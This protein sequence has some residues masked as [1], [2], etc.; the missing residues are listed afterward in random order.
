LALATVMAPPR[1]VQLALC[2]GAAALA[3]AAPSGVVR[4]A[5]LAV[6]LACVGLAWGALRMDALGDSILLERVGEARSARVVVTSA[7]RRWGGRARVFGEIRRFGAESIRERVLLELPN[8]RAPPRGAIAEIVR[9]RLY[10]P[11]GPETG[12]DERGWLAGRGVHVVVRAADVAVVGRRGG[13]G[14]VADRLRA[15][16]ERSLARG[17]GGERRALLRGIVLGDDSALSPAVRD[18]FRASG[19]A[20]LTA[21]SGQN[22]AIVALGIAA[23]AWLF[24]IGRL[25]IQVCA[26][27]AIGAYALAVG[28]EPSV[29][30][31]T[32]AGSVA[33]LAV[34]AARRVD[35]WHALSLGALL[36]LVWRPSSWLDPGFQLSFVAVA[37]I[38]ATVRRVQAWSEG[39]PRAFRPIIWT[40][41]A[42]ACSVTTAPVVWLHFGYVARRK[43][44]RTRSS[45]SLPSLSRC[46]LS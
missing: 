18:E 46:R 42:I 1:S 5:A 32:V 37:A 31:A 38:L 33:C 28:W 26:I 7:P 29:A 34:L 43:T 39:Y 40:S 45:E 10:A 22:V 14:G 9:A 41:V 24:A 20:H 15:H 19:L 35:G 17:A 25:G 8:E 13:I 23:L 16:V 27:L 36:L 30:R 4:V 12:F 2:C 44:K 21:V 6:L 3:V 11:R